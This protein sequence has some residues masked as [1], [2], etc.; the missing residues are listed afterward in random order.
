MEYKLRD[1]DTWSTLNIDKECYMWIN[2]AT[3]VTKAA[4]IKF[5]PTATQSG[6]NHHFYFDALI[7][8]LYVHRLELRKF[9]LNFVFAILFYGHVHI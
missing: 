9:F 4:Y 3:Q 7:C 8:P 2:P 6:Q 1:A 5:K